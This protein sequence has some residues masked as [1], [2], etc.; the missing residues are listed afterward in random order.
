MMHVKMF[1]SY[2]GR[3]L[4]SVCLSCAFSCAF[5][6]S[7]LWGKGLDEVEKQSLPQ[8]ALDSADSKVEAPK[9]DVGANAKS[10]GEA[11]AQKAAEQAKEQQAAGSQAAAEKK[12][13]PAD[14]AAA[15]PLEPSPLSPYVND[16][17]SFSTSFGPVIP[18]SDE[19][20]LAS[21]GQADWSLAYLL[22]LE[23]M[24]KVELRGHFRYAP[25][26]FTA[27]KDRASF[28]GVIESYGVG[29][30]AELQIHPKASTSLLLEMA[31]ASV[32]SKNI[33]R[34]DVEGPLSSGV[35]LYLGNQ[36][37]YKITESFDI[38][39]KLQAGFGVVSILQMGFSS[40][41]HF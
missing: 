33:D 26:Y 32:S 12:G 37:D 39:F 13:Q 36:T 15:K 24:E 7:S 22:P 19:N 38:G 3:G 30:S 17:L 11:G 31:F 1:D 9:Q 2:G 25:L 21:S 41:F 23:V 28:R 20:S 35:M 40:A 5:L 16:K 18:L 8:Q 27:N 34:T 6:A 4:G 10:L 29:G 14:K